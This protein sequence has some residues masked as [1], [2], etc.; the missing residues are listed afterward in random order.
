MFRIA[1]KDRLA[2]N[3]V[4]P[5]VSKFLPE[6]IWR[7]ENNFFGPA[8]VFSGLLNTAL[9][10]GSRSG[11]EILFLLRR[12]PNLHVIVVE[13]SPF[14][15]NEL[16]E[17][18][19]GQA[20]GRLR[21]VVSIGDAFTVRTRIDYL[22]V[23]LNG[24]DW[25]IIKSILLQHDVAY[26]AGEFDAVD[27]DPMELIRLSRRQTEKYFWRM[28][29]HNTPLSGSGG[30][31]KVEVSVVVPCYKV[32]TW[33]DHCMETLVGQSIESLEI[34]AV[35]D[36]SPD[37]TGAKL[38]SWAERFPGRVRVIH[39]V[40]GG[41]ASAR[42]TGLLSAIGEYVGFV[43]GDDW[44]ETPMF[45]ELYRSATLYAAEISQ[46]GY[47]EVYEATG[48][49]A[50]FPTAWEANPRDSLGIVN[51]PHSFLT[52][53]PTI[54]RRLYKRDFLM[55]NG[56]VFPE[57][58]RRFD[59]LPFQ[60]EA[61]SYAKRMSVLPDCYY[62][63]R[64][65]RPGQDVLASDAKLFVHFPIFDWIENRVGIWADEKLE[66]AL[67]NAKINT[68][69]WALTR[70]SSEFIG[71]Y[72]A[73]AAHDIFGRRRYVTNLQMLAIASRRGWSAVIFLIRAWLRAKFSPPD[74]IAS[75]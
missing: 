35:D 31:P 33:L 1:E 42:N 68:H 56:I 11:L 8:P 50:K 61:L 38:D 22:R 53:K 36:G 54:W 21:F 25:D 59:D 26:I 55:G 49:I 72:R 19:G 44:V 65:E 63:Y 70:L 14:L 39:K 71:R 18:I 66:R 64:L 67:V 9:Y 2:A 45:E 6:D 62:N 40:N 48:T 20:G 27:V 37:D 4:G 23:D 3:F 74:M 58:V 60:F 57:H 43:D 69:L 73:L 29:G 24:F 52:V 75:D 17:C 34:I 15:R 5:N 51:D 10:F 13:P 28:R 47:T 30:S 32:A 41:C 46:C 12:F 16:I 7:L